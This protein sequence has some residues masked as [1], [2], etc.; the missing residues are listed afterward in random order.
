MRKL[1]LCIL[2]T[3]ALSLAAGKPPT[4]ESVKAM[5]YFDLL[6]SLTENEELMLANA[7]SSVPDTINVLIRVHEKRLPKLESEANSWEA[8]IADWEK[9]R[10]DPT[11]YFDDGSVWHQRQSPADFE[12]AQN[13][14]R[15]RQRQDAEKVLHCR[16]TIAALRN[17]QTKLNKKSK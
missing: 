10:E 9:H 15:D 2:T 12:R 11:T 7:N 5:S 4:V 6:T 14:R 13:N 8:L 3:A 16:E 17:L 1:L